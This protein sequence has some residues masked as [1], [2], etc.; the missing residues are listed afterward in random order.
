MRTVINNDLYGLTLG[1]DEH[2]VRAAVTIEKI[3]VSYL[4][5][6]PP[7]W[8]WIPGDVPLYPRPA[9]VREAPP[10]LMLDDHS[11]CPCGQRFNPNKPVMERKCVLYTLIQA[12]P[13]RIQL[14]RCPSCPATLERAIGPEPRN[15]GIFNFDNRNLITHDL[16]DDYTS[17][18]TTSETP[19]IAWV[20]IM[21]RRYKDYKSHRKF[22]YHKTFRSA[23]FSYTKI[24]AFEGDMQCPECGPCPESVICDGTALRMNEKYVLPTVKPPTVSEEGS[25][26]RAS[27][28][29]GK[30]QVIEDPKLRKDIKRIIE[31]PR[32]LSRQELDVLSTSATIDRGAAEKLSN[33]LQLIVFVDNVCTALSAICSGLGLLFRK[34]YSAYAAS[35][36]LQPDRRYISLFKQVSILLSLTI[37]LR[38]DCHIACCRRV[39]DTDG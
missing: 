35:T 13:C 2:V 37:V 32:L 29:V 30:Q 10:L 12:I 33:C 1:I 17:S 34:A 28:Y 16:L 9:P 14:Q 36:G 23:W 21:S 38:A 7:A 8:C 20:K 24:Q 39:C 19:F 18:F 15:L 11:R 22:L 31:G 27:R 5:I 26:I 6:L 4:P 3:P 25:T